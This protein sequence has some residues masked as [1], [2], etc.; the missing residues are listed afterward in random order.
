MI[1][2]IVLPPKLTMI[3][4]VLFWGNDVL[5]RVTIQD[6]VQ[7]IADDAFLLCDNLKDIYYTGTRQQWSKITIGDS[8]SEL[9]KA[10]LHFKGE[11]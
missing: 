1:E 4:S 6:N 2:E 5:K 10:T 9:R 8:N 3:P 11:N 7:S